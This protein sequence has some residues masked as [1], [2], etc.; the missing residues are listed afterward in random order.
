[1]EEIFEERHKLALIYIL[2][3]TSIALNIFVIP[4]YLA[5]YWNILNVILWMVIFVLARKISNQH[6]RFKGKKDKLKT[7]FIIVTIYLI[8]YYLSGLFFGYQKSPFEHSFFG[9]LYNFVFYIMVIMLQEYTRSRLINN[10]RSK[11]GYTLITI[12]LI[13]TSYNYSTVFGNF[14]TGENIFKFIASDIYPAIIKGILCA[15]LVKLGSYELSLMFLLPIRIMEFITP[16]FPDLDW[17]LI[18]SF[19]SALVLMLYYYIYYEHMIN[20]ERFTRKQIE[21]ASPRKTAIAIVFVLAF[22]FFVAGFFP[23]QPVAIMSNSMAPQINRGDVVIVQKLNDEEKNKLKVGDI[24]QYSLEN[25]YVIHRIDAIVESSGGKVEYV[26]KGD[27][28]RSRDAK[29]VINSQIVGKVNL[30]VPYIGYPSVIFS[31]NVLHMEAEF[32]YEGN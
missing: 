28:N 24:I 14:N 23:V 18:V 17:F 2:I 7:T 9:L 27:N 29:S 31:E 25:K 12:I 11:V 10:T 32:L 13:L 1:M 16:I 4:N 22:T 3:I 20:V 5:I 21:Y 8:L 15:F 26:T 6:N 30:Y 19:D